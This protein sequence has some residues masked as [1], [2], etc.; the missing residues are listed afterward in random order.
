MTVPAKQTSDTFSNLR[1]PI[2]LVT[3][4]RCKQINSPT[5]PEAVRKTEKQNKLN[6]NNSE[7]KL[8]MFKPPEHCACVRRTQ[9]QPQNHF[10]KCLSDFRLMFQ[11]FGLR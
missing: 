5:K 1:T 3:I 11:G 2:G 9:P 6:R 7:S 8:V 4:R 10:L